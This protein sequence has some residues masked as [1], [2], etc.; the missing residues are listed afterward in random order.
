MR[1]NLGDDCTLGFCFFLFLIL[2][3]D[4]LHNIYLNINLDL[5]GDI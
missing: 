4:Q 3:D 1:L 2:S 5:R